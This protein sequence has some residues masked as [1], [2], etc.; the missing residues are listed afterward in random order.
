M[1][2]CSKRLGKVALVLLAQALYYQFFATQHPFTQARGLTNT[3][4]WPIQEVLGE[5][6]PDC[7]KSFFQIMARMTPV[8]D[9]SLDSTLTH[10]LTK[11][12]TRVQ[13]GTTQALG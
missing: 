12:A 9:T 5:N 6:Q 7:L 10:L 8:T 11:S 2:V 4:R 1:T 3:L 13:Q